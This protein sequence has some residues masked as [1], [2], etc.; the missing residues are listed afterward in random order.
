MARRSTRSTTTGRGKGASRKAPAAKPARSKPSRSCGQDTAFADALSVDFVCHGASAISR[1]REDDP[2]TYMKI[3]ASVLPKA[4]IDNIDP[5][6]SL[7]DEELHERARRLAEE[8]GLGS[9][10]DPDDAGKKDS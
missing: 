1:L 6:D 9:R 3:C 2:V 7:T 4:L 8:A 10:P 5:L